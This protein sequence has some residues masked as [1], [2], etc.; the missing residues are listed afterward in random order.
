MRA[1]AGRTFVPAVA[2]LAIASVVMF[3]S[4][5][6]WLLV[7]SAMFLFAGIALGVFA[8]ATPEFL[9]GDF[10]EDAR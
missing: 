1:R 2:I 8:I 4:S 7:I 3:L 6:E 10:E 9:E 5:A